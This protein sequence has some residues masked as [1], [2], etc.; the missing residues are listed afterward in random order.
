M[1]VALEECRS[2]NS[3]YMADVD[4]V[5]EVERQ[6]AVSAIKA[7]VGKAGTLVGRE[8]IQLHGGIAMTDDYV[9]GHYF[10]RLT[11]ITRLFGDLEWHLDRIADLAG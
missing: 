1:F 7:Q 10:K 5:N 3:V 6:Q 8:A 11:V 4:S 2:L 9:A